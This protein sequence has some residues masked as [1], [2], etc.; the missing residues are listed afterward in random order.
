MSTAQTTRPATSGADSRLPVTVLSGFLGSGK[1]T[2]LNH[3]LTNRDG[4]RVAVIVNDMSEV[5][6]DAQLVADG[7]AHLDRVEE[8]LVEM[9]NG[10]ICCTLREDLLEEVAKL[11]RAGRFD[12]LLIESTGISEPLPV[13]ETFVFTDELGVALSDIAR[14]DTMVTT[15]DAAAFLDDYQAPDFLQTRGIA[16][17]PEDERSIASLLVDQVEFADTIVVNKVDL[18]S[19]PELE[20]LVAILQGLN[21]RAD[22]L[23][24]SYGR[25]DL[26]EVLDTGRF[27]FD[28]A[29][30]AAGWMATMRGEET[31]ETDEYGVTS[32]VWRAR[33]PF[34]PERLHKLLSHGWPGVLRMKGYSW[35][36]SRPEQAWELSKAGRMTGYQ[37]LGLW[38][39]AVDTARWPTDPAARSEILA[40]MEDPWGDRRQEIVVI[41]VDMD[42]DGIRADFDRCLLDASELNRAWSDWRSLPDPFPA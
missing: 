32:F 31:P 1:T 19:E 10:C 26:D 33:A 28:E 16:V 23:T 29:E 34:H 13:A 3:V 22:V 41:G 14:L 40:A 37:P 5:N 42:E 38:W 24:T 6:I 4:K 18:V 15:V 36:A 12:Y 8:R 35:I 30:Q 39:S 27:D 9:S 11:A 17:G 25:V 20:R 2:L 7:G 21:P